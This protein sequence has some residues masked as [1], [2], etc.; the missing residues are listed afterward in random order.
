MVVF[1]QPMCKNI[2]QNKNF[3]HVGVKLKANVQPPNTSSDGIR[4]CI[5]VLGRDFTSDLP[6]QS[7]QKSTHNEPKHL[8][9]PAYALWRPP[10]AANM[11]LQNFCQ[12]WINFWSSSY[13]CSCG[14]LHPH[15]SLNEDSTNLR[16]RTKRLRESLFT[17]CRLRMRRRGWR[18][19]K[20]NCRVKDMVMPPGCL[21]WYDWR[22]KDCSWWLASNIVTF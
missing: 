3:A 6:I 5:C 19:I 4:R 10:N 11:D 21:E 15:I 12:I 18:M 1:N 20:K 2:R 16:I 14:H 8:A 17:K 9:E 13:H 22:I 7:E